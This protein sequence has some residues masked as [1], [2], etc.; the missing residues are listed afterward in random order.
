[1][2]HTTDGGDEDDLTGSEN[3]GDARLTSDEES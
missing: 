2:Q 1:M 3:E